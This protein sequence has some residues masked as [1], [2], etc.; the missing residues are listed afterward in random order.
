MIFITQGASN[1][2]KIATAIVASLA[3]GLA[4]CTL[5][6]YVQSAPVNQVGDTIQGGVIKGVAHGGQNPLNG[7]SV[8]LYAAGNTASAGTYGTG[9][10]SLL[11]SAVLTNNTSATDAA[12]NT[13]IGA[14]DGHGN[15][16][17]STD[18]G[19]FFNLTGD[20]SCPGAVTSGGNTYPSEVYVLIVGGDSGSGNN[21]N[22]ALLAA[23]GPC[24]SASALATAYPFISVNEVTTVAAVYALQQFMSAPSGSAGVINIG[25]PSTNLVGL[26]NAFATAANMVNI[27]A[28]AAP[29]V[30]SWV[31]V[32]SDHVN[33]IA[34]ILSYCINSSGST[35]SS[36]YASVTPPSST[37]LS[38]KNVPAS[39]L[40]APADT[41]QAAWFMAQF[42][43]NTAGVSC[44]ASGGAFYCVPG[45]G[46]PF[47]PALAAAPNDWTLAMGYAPQSPNLNSKSNHNVLFAANYMALDPY[48][49]AWFS[50]YGDISGVTVIAP[51]GAY[52]QDPVTSYTVGANSGYAANLFATYGITSAVSYTRTM[53]HI[54]GLA[55]DSLGNVWLADWSSTVYTN[56]STISGGTYTCTGTCIF[57][58]TAMFPA[59]TGPGI[60]TSADATPTGFYIGLNP[61]AVAADASGNVFFT[62]AGGS[63]NPGSKSIVKINSSGTYT[64]G[65]SL[66]TH[67][68]NIIVDNNTSATNG[69]EV[70]ANDQEGCVVTTGF[71]G[72]VILQFAAGTAAANSVGFTG[73]TTGCTSSVVYKTSAVMGAVLGMAVDANNGIWFVSPS[74]GFSI[75]S[76]TSMANIVTYGVSTVVPSGTYVGKAVIGTASGSTITSTSSNSVSSSAGAGGMVNGQFVAVDGAGNAWVSSYGY[77]AVSG[78]TSSSPIAEF[79]VSNAGTSSMAINAISG[80]NGYLH[81]ETGSVPQLSESIAIDLSGNVWVTDNNNGG[82]NYVTILVGAATPVAP[83]IPGKLGVAP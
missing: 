17:I 65:G 58:T 70:W 28:G 1:L 73:N 38:T 21:P 80:A 33:T 13:G 32:E 76:P 67:P 50:N 77:S 49:N 11:S 18:S 44:G 12:S 5:G 54:K 29:G 61:W 55:S 74:T 75:A 26:Q 6:G 63:S 37:T 40:N 3:I 22:V 24:A 46:N 34:D 60:I 16:Y 14:I 59:A 78:Y 71:Y 15:Y 20:Y 47:T 56:E 83:P 82:T 42:P 69:P 53:N 68:Y 2:R 8:Y 66:G 4:G 64:A 52:L 41:V 57:G 81:S 25:T 27:G 39:S 23:L 43:T 31:S 48:G 19:G 10:T 51:N 79:S 9:A 72:S 35:C 45:S 7:A 36:L 62:L 30:N